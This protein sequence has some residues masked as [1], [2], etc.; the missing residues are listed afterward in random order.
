MLPTHTQHKP[1]GNE[2]AKCKALVCRHGCFLA[3]LEKQSVTTQKHTHKKEKREKAKEKRLS[4]SKMKKKHIE[5]LFTLFFS[6]PFFKSFLDD[7]TKCDCLFGVLGHS[8]TCYGTVVSFWLN[9]F[10]LQPMPLACLCSL[11]ASCACFHSWPKHGQQRDFM[12]EP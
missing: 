12:S 2:K 6:I 11:C 1:N 4:N 7:V 3:N 9:P 5:C 10:C 8:R